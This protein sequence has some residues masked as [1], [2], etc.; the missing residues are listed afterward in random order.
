MMDCCDSFNEIHVMLDW[1]PTLVNLIRMEKGM[2][3]I[4]LTTWLKD[5]IAS[6][7]KVGYDASEPLQTLP[8]NVHEFLSEAVNIP[9]EY[10]E[11]C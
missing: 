9:S 7:Q 5:K 2:A 1:I 10:V 11:G 8:H 4:W 3:F 6:K